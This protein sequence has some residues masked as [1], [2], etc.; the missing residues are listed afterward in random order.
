MQKKKR[1]KNRIWFT[2][3][4]NAVGPNGKKPTKNRILKNVKLID[5]TFA[6][7][8]LTHLPETKR[9]E[10]IF[11]KTEQTCD[12]KPANLDSKTVWFDCGFRLNGFLSIHI[13]QLL[14]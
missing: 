5:Q 1:L 9:L 6:C 7:N 14:G 4:Q 3:D 12:Y 2:P 8:V 13:H 11:D 10:I